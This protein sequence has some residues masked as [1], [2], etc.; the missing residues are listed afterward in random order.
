M[1]CLLE[2]FSVTSASALVSEDPPASDS[3]SS[4]HHD[5]AAKLISRLHMRQLDEA[6]AGV[7]SVRDE[8]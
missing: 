8:L 5:H 3:F 1:S 4:L 2:N 6:E 7:F